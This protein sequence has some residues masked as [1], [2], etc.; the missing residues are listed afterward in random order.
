ML[1]Y[2]AHSLLLPLS[3]NC[4]NSKFLKVFSLT[5]WSFV[6]FHSI[7]LFIFSFFKIDSLNKFVEF[8]IM[9]FYM[10]YL[11]VL[12]SLIFWR[13]EH[14]LLKFLNWKTVAIGA[15]ISFLGMYAILHYNLYFL[16]DKNYVDS[17]FS[18]TLLSLYFCFMIYLIFNL[19]YLLDKKK[20]LLGSNLFVNYSIFLIIATFMI[21]FFIGALMFSKTISINYSVF[22]ICFYFIF[23]NFKL[24]KYLLNTGYMLFP[25]ISTDNNRGLYHYGL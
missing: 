13:K 4:Y 23:Y 1:T 2:L 16:S 19:I 11:L 3:S 17:I 22:F 15:I 14:L 25:L 21:W 10:A 7:R 20:L 8:F 12:Y 24:Y 5:I 18:F 6:L 9:L